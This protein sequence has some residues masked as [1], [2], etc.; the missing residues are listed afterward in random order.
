[1]Q[2]RQLPF[3]FARL[4]GVIAPRARSAL[5]LEGK[6]TARVSHQDVK[7][8]SNCRRSILSILLIKSNSVRG[9]FRPQAFLPN[10][11]TNCRLACSV[12][13]RAL[14]LGSRENSAQRYS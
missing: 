6:P 2:I 11:T 7:T 9:E 13:V 10:R 4:Q 14:V 8:A 12:N 1:M 3:V 5:S